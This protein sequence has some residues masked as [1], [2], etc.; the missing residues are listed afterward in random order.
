MGVMGTK[1]RRLFRREAE[2]RQTLF[3]NSSIKRESEIRTDAN[4]E[5]FKTWCKI[6]YCGLSLLLGGGR[7]GSRRSQTDRSVSQPR[8]SGTPF[9]RPPRLP[10]TP[11]VFLRFQPFLTLLFHMLISA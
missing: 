6:Q 1:V 7:R 8:L 10:H 4:D 2:E 3:E 5:A 9:L 11:S